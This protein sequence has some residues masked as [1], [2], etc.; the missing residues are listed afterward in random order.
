MSNGSIAHHSTFLI[1]FFGVYARLPL[2]LA[3]LLGL[4]HGEL[5][6][7]L[8]P[9]FA[10]NYVCEALAMLAGLTAPTLILSGSGG[11]NLPIEQQ[12]YLV[13]AVLIFC[14]FGTAV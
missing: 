11:V 14:S 12:Q 9:M 10:E 7:W 6:A 2:L 13:S 4:Q 3:L 5:K 1:R 8:P